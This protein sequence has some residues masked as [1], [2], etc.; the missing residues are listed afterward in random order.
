MKDLV[1][2]IIYKSLKSKDIFDDKIVTEVNDVLDFYIAE[3]YHHNYFAKNPGN[4]Y[5]QAVINPKLAK[6]RLSFSD[7]ISE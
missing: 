1:L 2:L 6:L 5:C 7:L 3:D 4:A